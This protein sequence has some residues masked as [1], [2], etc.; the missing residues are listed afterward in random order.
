MKPHSPHAHHTVDE[1]V[2]GAD[3][4]CAHGDA[5]GLRHVARQLAHRL[6]DWIRRALTSVSDAAM[7]GGDPFACWAAVRPAIVEFLR[8]DPERENASQ[9]C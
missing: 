5:G 9:R 8:D 3:W 7:S 2:F 6:P 4:A 1:L